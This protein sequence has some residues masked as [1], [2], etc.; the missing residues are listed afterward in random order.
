MNVREFQEAMS[1]ASADFTETMREA[2]SAYRQRVREAAATF[3]GSDPVPV[4]ENVSPD[5]TVIKDD[6]A[7]WFKADD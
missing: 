6:P 1:A 3:L 4:L 2:V 7:D 5:V